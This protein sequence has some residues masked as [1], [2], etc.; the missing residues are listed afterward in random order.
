MTY[1]KYREK[2]N[3]IFVLCSNTA[4]FCFLLIAYDTLL[5]IAIAM[6]RKSG[7]DTYRLYS[8]HKQLASPE[9]DEHLTLL[10][11][12][13]K[14]FYSRHGRLCHNLQELTS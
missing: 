13:S 10:V 2:S 3:I 5:Q 14:V 9:I 12:Q 6:L 1:Y 7:R 11:P 4:T 8:D